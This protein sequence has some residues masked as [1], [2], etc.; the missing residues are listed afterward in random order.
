MVRDI[1]VARDAELAQAKHLLACKEE[2]LRLLLNRWEER[3]GQLAQARA[4]VGSALVRC[5]LDSLH[6]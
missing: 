3:E 1:L 2:E 4:E 6:L 5:G